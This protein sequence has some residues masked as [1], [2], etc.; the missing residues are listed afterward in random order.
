MS[1]SSLL[2]LFLASLIGSPHCA[3]MCGGF[4][5]FYS[6]NSPKS[7][8]PHL[9]YNLGRLLT[10]LT[11][12][13]LGG[14]LGTSISAFAD[15]YGIHNGAAILVGTLLIVTG[16]LMLFQSAIL[17][18]IKTYFAHTTI[19]PLRAVLSS[20]K[21]RSPFLVAGA[22]GLL[23]TLLP[24]G[25]LYSFVA[26]AVGS[27]SPLEGMIIMAIFWAGTLPVMASLGAI[28]T[29]IASPLRAYVPKIASLLMIAAGIFSFS[30]H[31]SA[32]GPHRNHCH[33]ESKNILE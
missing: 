29:V 21:N 16:I 1:I 31:L 12:G 26:L 4:V 10:Y 6:S 20:H 27:G 23:T 17:G 9:Y 22:L 14:Y 5:A 19:A 2:T 11:L 30:E 3:G 25:W 7:I 32:A 15:R 18:R 13:A 28:T 24:C 33:T 8:L